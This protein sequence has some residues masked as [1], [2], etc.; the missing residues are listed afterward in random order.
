ML[1]WLRCVF[2]WL[3]QLSFY[4]PNDMH[5]FFD[6]DDKLHITRTWGWEKHKYIV[7]YKYKPPTVGGLGAK[8]LAALERRKFEICS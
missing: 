5:D 2:F 1:G 4:F 7:E 3:F 6:T 8:A